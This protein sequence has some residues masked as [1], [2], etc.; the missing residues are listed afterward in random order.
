MLK[1]SSQGGMLNFSINTK[2]LNEAQIRVIRMVNS[3][4]LELLNSNN[5]AQ[6]FEKSAELMRLSAI[7]IK[8]SN[9]NSMGPENHMT[10]STATSE[11]VRIPYADQAIEFSIDN[12]FEIFSGVNPSNKLINFDN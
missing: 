5:E 12:L 2:N 6:F 11:G 8:Q 3:V 7:A 1:Y 4:L 9:F 10:T